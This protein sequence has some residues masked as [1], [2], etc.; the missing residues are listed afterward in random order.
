MNALCAICLKIFR[1]QWIQNSREIKNFDLLLIFFQYS[2]PRRLI[3]G[4]SS[5]L[6]A[7][8]YLDVQ[9]FTKLKKEVNFFLLTVRF[10]L[11]SSVFKFLSS[12]LHNPY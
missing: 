7:L 2:I 5:K 4:E 11:E 10:G 3:G 8:I 6:T 9:D 1:N 12:S